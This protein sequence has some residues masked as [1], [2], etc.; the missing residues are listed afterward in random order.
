MSHTYMQNLSEQNDA[1]RIM[2]KMIYLFKNMVFNE[3]YSMP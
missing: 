3:P 2:W 1:V